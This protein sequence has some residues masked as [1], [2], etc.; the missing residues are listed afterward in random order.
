ML[1][2]NPDGELEVSFPPNF[3]G[4]DGI[5]MLQD[6]GGFTTFAQQVIVPEEIYNEHPFVLPDGIRLVLTD[7]P[8]SHYSAYHSDYWGLY[9]VRAK[10]EPTVTNVLGCRNCDLL[11]E[12]ERSG[13]SIRVNVVIHWSWASDK[14]YFCQEENNNFNAKFAAGDEIKVSYANFG[15]P[16]KDNLALT[17]VHGQESILPERWA[18]NRIRYGKAGNRD[19]DFNVY[20][21]QD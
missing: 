3:F 17:F 15:M 13:D 2:S 16:D 21:S 9:C 4:H 20:V 8:V 10:I 1:I 12:N 7:N 11:F 19:R 6:T 18:P 5:K 14:I